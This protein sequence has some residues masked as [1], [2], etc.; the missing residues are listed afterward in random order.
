[1]NTKVWYLPYFKGVYY[2]RM[3]EPFSV[4]NARM[5]RMVHTRYTT[6]YTLNKY[7]YTYTHVIIS[8]T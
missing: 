6:N 2:T 1:M 7:M 3:I 5:V 8:Y 4:V